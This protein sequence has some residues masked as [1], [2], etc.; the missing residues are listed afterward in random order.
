MAIYGIEIWIRDA[1]PNQYGRWLWIPLRHDPDL[2]SQYF[3]HRQLYYR[4]L[5]NTR[6]VF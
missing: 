6:L 5:F 3:F 4:Y 1:D 2:A